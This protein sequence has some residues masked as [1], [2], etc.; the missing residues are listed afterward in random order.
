ML[1]FEAGP[2]LN[3]YSIGQKQNFLLFLASRY[4]ENKEI[5]VLIMQWYKNHW[6]GGGGGGKSALALPHYSVKL[7]T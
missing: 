7:G 4:P 1:I 6:G 2:T 5:L 3:F